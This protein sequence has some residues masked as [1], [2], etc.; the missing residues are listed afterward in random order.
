MLRIAALVLGALLLVQLAR[1]AWRCNPLGGV[2]IPALPTLAGATNQAGGDKVLAF[3]SRTNATA[4]TNGPA[5]TGTNAVRKLETAKAETN[6]PGRMNSALSASNVARAEMPKVPREAMMA[7]MGMMP[8]GGPGKAAALPA[9]I[10]A[11][12]DRVTES[13]ILGP[14][15]RPLPMAL[16]GIA[17]D[18]A[19]LRSSNGQTGLAKEGESVGGLKLLKIG[20]NRVLVEQ[21]GQKKELTI[22]S[23]LGGDALLAQ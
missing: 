8:P 13:E 10:Q 22:F 5:I 1:V 9:A 23:G 14:V 17:G 19:F 21:E 12:V 4:K 20:I 11:R 2:K 3:V 15:I 18:V 6:P 16:L 7:G